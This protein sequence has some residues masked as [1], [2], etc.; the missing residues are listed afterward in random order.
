[1]IKNNVQD[2]GKKIPTNGQLNKQKIHNKKFICFNKI[3]LKNI[4]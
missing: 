3:A 2:G 1:M 4:F